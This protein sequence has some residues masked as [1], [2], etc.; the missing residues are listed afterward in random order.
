MPFGRQAFNAKQMS[1]IDHPKKGRKL[2][3][4]LPSESRTKV[5]SERMMVTS[6]LGFALP[7]YTVPVFLRSIVQTASSPFSFLIRSSKIPLVCKE[8]HDVREITTRAARMKGLRT[9][10]IWLFFS[11]SLNWVNAA[12]SWLM[13]SEAYKSRKLHA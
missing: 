3:L 11:V 7:L 2:V 6:A 10:L 9:F 13:I 8:E 4:T 5:S 1:D 12:P